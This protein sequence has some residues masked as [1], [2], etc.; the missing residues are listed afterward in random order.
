LQETLKTTMEL[1][2]S[3]EIVW[4]CFQIDEIQRRREQKI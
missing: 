2:E 1:M 3:E 4:I